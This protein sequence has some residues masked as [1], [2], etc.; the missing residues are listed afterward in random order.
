MLIG[1]A[2][3]AIGVIALGRAVANCINASALSSD[4]SRVRQILANR[5]AEIETTPGQ[6]DKTKVAKIDTGYGEVKLTQ[7]AQPEQLTEDRRA[8]T[9]IQRVTLT[10]SWMRGGVEQQKAIAFYVY[11]AQ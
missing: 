11:R 9:G 2:I 8:V 4:D 10:A 6:P 5:M 7:K 1:V 3:F